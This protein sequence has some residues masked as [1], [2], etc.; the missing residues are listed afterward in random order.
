[1]LLAQIKSGNDSYK[2][3]KMKLDKYFIFL[4]QRNNFIMLVQKIKY[5]SDLQQFNQVI[6]IMEKT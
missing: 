1:M 6:I 2:C 5:L 3:K 4:Y